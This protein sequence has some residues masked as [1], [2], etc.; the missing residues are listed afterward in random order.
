MSQSPNI[1]E[2]LEIELL[3]PADKRRISVDDHAAFREAIHGPAANDIDQAAADPIVD[4]APRYQPKYK[5]RGV[6][7]ILDQLDRQ[8]NRRCKP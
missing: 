4:R 7:S 6:L 2:P 5:V 8:S 3:L 1:R